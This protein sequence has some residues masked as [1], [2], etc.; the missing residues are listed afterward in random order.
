MIADHQGN[1]PLDLTPFIGRDDLLQ[2]SAELLR[3]RRLL[4]LTGSGGVG[5]SRLAAR[6]ASQIA[7]HFDGAWM[8]DFSGLGSQ[9][10]VSIDRVYSHMMLALGIQHQQSAGLEIILAH[11]AS[12]RV[13]LILDSCD[14]LVPQLRS[15]VVT[16][17]QAAPHLRILATS[18]QRLG[19]DGEKT[20][21]VPPLQLPDSARLFVELAEAAGASPAALADD[22]AVEELCRHLDGLPLAIKLAASRAMTLSLQELTDR[23]EDRFTLLSTDRPGGHTAQLERVVDLSYEL[24]TPAEKAVWTAT[25]AFGSFTLAAA[26]A[27]AKTAGIDDAGVINAVTGLVD[28]S[29]LTPA[30]ATHPARYSMLDTLREYGLRQ[31]EQAGT[32]RSARDAH[33]DYYRAFLAQAATAWFCPTELDTLAAVRRE[34]PEIM[35]AIDHSMAT[36]AYTDAR[37]ICINLVRSRAPFFWGFLKTA[38]DALQRVLAAPDS[39][40]DTPQGSIAY[41]ATSA[42]SAW[43][44]ATQGSRDR[45]RSTLKRAQVLLEKHGIGTIPPLLFADGGSSALLEGT[46]E[47]IGLLLAARQLSATPDAKGDRH[48]A[49]MMWAIATTF[50]GHADAAITANDLYLKE[51]EQAGAPWAISWALWGAALAALRAQNTT[52]AT[53]LIS[54]GLRMQRDMGDSWGGTWSLALSAWILAAQLPHAANPHAEARRAAWLLGA[55]L[56]RQQQTGVVIAGL[57]PL[58]ERHDR[59]Y[60]QIVDVLGELAAEREVAAGH[61]GHKDAFRV[62]LGEPVSRRT[63]ADETGLTTREREIAFLVAEGLTSPEVSRRLRIAAR[64]ADTHIRNVLNKLELPNRAALAAWASQ[65]TDNNAN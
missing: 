35:S 58:A 31:L 15:V 19:V 49:T 24:C 54:R 47:A 65:Q 6:V 9:T 61:R 64:T 33:R 21:L 17:L 32:T 52:D 5:K 13:F 53:E 42:C 44:A 45:T 63:S 26:E 14:R 59:A 40:V 28:K 48:Q 7:P 30:T 20:V 27:V 3:N 25:S 29:V 1:L 8:I 34:Q 62:A 37:E 36:G 23:T 12:R 2:K 10:E 56:A 43:I 18:R 41:A 57:R 55:S 38:D 16:L 22:R 11:L 4:T 39:N 50:A 60:T 51:A 46:P